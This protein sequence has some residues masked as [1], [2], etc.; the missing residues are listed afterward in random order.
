MPHEI[1]F[2]SLNYVL[3]EVGKKYYP[4][5]GKSIDNL[6]SVTKCKNFKKTT[7]SGCVI[8]KISNSFKIYPEI[9]KKR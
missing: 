9:G 2:R 3:K 1:V 6:I 7:L 8:E 4:P 5:R